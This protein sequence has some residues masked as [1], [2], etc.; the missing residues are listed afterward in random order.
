MWQITN[1]QTIKDKV[2]FIFLITLYLLV[3]DLHSF[4]NLTFHNDVLF[5]VFDI[6]STFIPKDI[7]INI[8]NRFDYKINYNEAILFIARA[9]SGGFACGKNV[10]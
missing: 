5:F 4:N 9:E 10:T 3:F 6:I 8:I 7:R 1:I 2:S